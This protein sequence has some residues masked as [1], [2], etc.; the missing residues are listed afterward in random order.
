ML[1]PSCDILWS[2]VVYEYFVSYRYNRYN[3]YSYSHFIHLYTIINYRIQYI[4]YGPKRHTKPQNR[5]FGTLFLI[6]LL[7]WKIGSYNTE[8]DTI[9]RYVTKLCYNLLY[10]IVS[11]IVSH[12]ACPLVPSILYILI[13]LLLEYIEYPRVILD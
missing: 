13:I 4:Q 1:V 7:S 6:R 11:C 5:Q 10:S 12:I 8:T 2:C 9:D 3:R